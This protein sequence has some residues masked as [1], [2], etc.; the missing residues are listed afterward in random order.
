VDQARGKPAA[1]LAPQVQRPRLTAPWLWD[2]GG[3][4]AL[5]YGLLFSCG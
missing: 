4:W 2:L 5:V 3:F 1:P